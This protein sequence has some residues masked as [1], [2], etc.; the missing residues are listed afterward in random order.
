VPTDFLWQ[1]NP[2]QLS[3]NGKGTIEGAGI[4][5]L[6]PYWMAKLFLPGADGFR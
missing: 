5:Y 2:F 4:D 1:R 6:L 3:G